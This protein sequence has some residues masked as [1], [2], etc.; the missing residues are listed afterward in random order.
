MEIY[1]RLLVSLVVEFYSSG[2]TEQ[3]FEFAEKS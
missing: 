2:L 3:L 1:K